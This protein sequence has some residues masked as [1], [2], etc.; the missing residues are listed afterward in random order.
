MYLSLRNV[1]PNSRFSWRSKDLANHAGDT[2][3]QLPYFIFSCHQER[4][5]IGEQHSYDSMQR[6][7]FSSGGMSDS[8][9]WGSWGNMTCSCLISQSL[10][11]PAPLCTI[12]PRPSSPT[13]S[14]HALLLLDHCILALV[15]MG[16]HSE[17]GACLA[18]NPPTSVRRQWFHSGS[19]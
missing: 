6:G 16:F 10:K 18:E 8:P 3:G 12:W 14:H 15:L 5:L 4:F 17:S 11:W 7:S 2:F 1:V 19:I 13:S 9:L